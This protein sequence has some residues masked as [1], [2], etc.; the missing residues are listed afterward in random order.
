MAQSMINFRMDEDLKKRMEQTCK[1]M[2]LT[3]TAAF[4]MFATK[5][6][7]EQRIPFEI[8]GDPFYSEENI[9]VLE[10][11]IADLESGKS[12]LKEHE[13]IEVE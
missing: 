4:T 6:T 11:R 2:G 3:M 12:T 1:S 7:R 8:T 13:L 10:K 9:A 5:V